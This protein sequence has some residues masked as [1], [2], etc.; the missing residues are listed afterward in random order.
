MGKTTFSGPVISLNG[1]GGGIGVIGPGPKPKVALTS[2][3]EQALEANTNYVLSAWPIGITSLTLP[4]QEVSREGDV[5]LIE[6]QDA[7]PSVGP[8]NVIKIGTPGET[9]SLE[10]TAY[11][12]LA[13]AIRG[14]VLSTASSVFFNM[15]GITDGGPGVGSKVIAS[16]NGEKWRVDADLTTSGTGAVANTS[17]YGAASV[18]EEA[19][20]AKAEEAKKEVKT[21]TK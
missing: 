20:K 19:K 18:K 5:I 16:F 13:G 4:L 2:N 1:Y 3:A 8:T 6:S 12:P 10:S 15:Q 21:I 9:L 17:A 7:F 14:F 11:I